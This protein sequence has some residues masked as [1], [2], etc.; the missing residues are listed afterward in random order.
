[1]EIQHEGDRT[2]GSGPPDAYLKNSK[3]DQ[4]EKQSVDCVPV[5][6]DNAEQVTDFAVAGS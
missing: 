1:M 3:A 2:R 6:P 5:N 4:P